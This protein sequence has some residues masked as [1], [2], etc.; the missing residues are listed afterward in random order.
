MLILSEDKND[1]RKLNAKIQRASTELGKNIEVKV[2]SDKA[3]MAAF[4]VVNGRRRFSVNY[5]LKSEVGE[6]SLDVVK[7]WIKE[8]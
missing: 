2:I 7:E 8:L 4:G 5:K 3:Q 6:P 1:C